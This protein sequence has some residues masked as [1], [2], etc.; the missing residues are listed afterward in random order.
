MMIEVAAAILHDDAGSVLICQRDGKD[1]CAGLWEFPGGK[2]EHGED[3]H[4][5]L[6]RECREELEIQ[7]EVGEL[8]DEFCYAYPE[9]T[10][11]FRFYLAKI[12]S[13][14]PCRRVHSQ[15]VWAAKKILNEYAFC[16]ADEQLV[17][18]LSAEEN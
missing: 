17:A 6:V 16:P 9:K 10:I 5:C 2:R 12:V 13:G 1:D 8:Y 11:H 14:V 7:I 18:R 3:W 15:L 4:E